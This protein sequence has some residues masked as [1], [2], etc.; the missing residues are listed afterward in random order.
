M[1]IILQRKKMKKIALVSALMLSTIAVA[2]E[3]EITPLVGY[4]ITE[5]NL[6]LDNY[7]IVGGE[8]QYNG[9]DFPIKPEISFLYSMADYEN[10]FLDYSNNA[11]TN[12]MR[13]LLNGVYQFDKIG[14]VVPLAK[15]G[16][17]YE[18]MDDAYAGN[19]DGSGVL[20][21]AL[22]IKY[23][24]NDMLSL[25]LETLYMAK[26]NAARYD[27]N[28]AILAGLA[29]SFGNN[30]TKTVE[31]QTIVEEP[32]AIFEEV[33]VPVVV[34]PVIAEVA[35]IEEAPV[36]EKVVIAKYVPEEYEGTIEVDEKGDPKK[37][38]LGVSFDHNSYNLETT[39]DSNIDKFVD[40]LN[41]HPEYKVE[42]VGF[43]DSINTYEY[44]QVL[45]QKRANLVKEIL[46]TNGISED[47]LTT[48]G[49][50]E[51]NPIASNMYKAGRALNRRVEVTI[52]K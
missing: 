33:I 39:Y 50:G 15:A 27:S 30:E 52:V 6:N 20:S 22:G 31:T 23:P 19:N 46:I 10:D 44:N 12:V 4:N 16:I 2:N 34:E 36:V 13:F 9:F 3:Y 48:T 28:L 18:T 25:K 26:Y 47:R 1:T 40:Y 37:I 42:I 35:V 32:V 49:G 21:A 51:Y 24:F 43:A 38:N 8:L 5:G 14:S 29:I 11:D 17:G 41:K 7:T 45:S